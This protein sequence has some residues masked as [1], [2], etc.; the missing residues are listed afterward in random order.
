M[1]ILFHLTHS[2]SPIEGNM[3]SSSMAEPTAINIIVQLENTTIKE[4]SELF[5]AAVSDVF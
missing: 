5:A 3:I 1:I 4:V 2:L